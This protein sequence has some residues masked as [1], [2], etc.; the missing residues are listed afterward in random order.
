MVSYE[1]YARATCFLGH[2]IINRKRIYNEFVI[3]T[4]T[5]VLPR[6]GVLAI[7]IKIVL[8]KCVKK[9]SGLVTVYTGFPFFIPLVSLPRAYS[10]IIPRV[11]Y[12]GS[13]RI[14]THTNC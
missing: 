1:F 11:V 10:I 9:K 14:H 4:E 6:D 7:R 12:D 2:D 13:T 8:K 3:C 5:S